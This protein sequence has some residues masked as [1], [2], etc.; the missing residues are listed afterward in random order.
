M[1]LVREHAIKNVKDLR[2]QVS[3]HHS[4]AV[5]ARV[6]DPRFGPNGSSRAWAE[7]LPLVVPRIFAQ[8]M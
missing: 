8:H 3:E 4:Y 2:L 1:Q 6:F 5:S 7:P